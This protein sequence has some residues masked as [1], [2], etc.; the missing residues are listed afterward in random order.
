MGAR[1]SRE[2]NI[3]QLFQLI[4][5]S[6]ETSFNRHQRA[7]YER[8]LLNF[9]VNQNNVLELDEASALELFT[10]ISKFLRPDRETH[11]T[12]A[13]RMHFILLLIFFFFLL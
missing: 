7:L 2:Q 6:K 1:I 10:A 4:S 11:N 3:Y 13:Q 9:Q 5:S 8:L 12:S